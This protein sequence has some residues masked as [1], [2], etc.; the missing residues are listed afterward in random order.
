[1][2]TLEK[3]M[4]LLFVIMEHW[5]CVIYSSW[6][7]PKSI[8]SHQNFI[9]SKTK[10]CP[11]LTIP[12]SI[13][14][15]A[16]VCERYRFFSTFLKNPAACWKCLLNK[17]VFWWG[18]QLLYTEPITDKL[19]LS[20]WFSLAAFIILNFLSMFTVLIVKDMRKLL[21]VLVHVVL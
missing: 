13:T 2:F 19:V 6:C 17:S 4:C 20:S 16:F 11:Q 14:P 1:M 9:L 7:E 21:F 8:I 3:S 15:S 10:T 12:L 5:L 18:L